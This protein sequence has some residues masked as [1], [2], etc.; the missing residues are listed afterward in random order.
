MLS[1]RDIQRKIRTVRNIQQ[2][3]RA[4][5]TVSS[6][7]LRKAEERIRAARPYADALREMV[8]RLGGVE[9]A[10][11]LL[12]RREVHRVCVVAISADKGLAG[13]Y[14]TNVIRDAGTLVRSLGNALT[15]PVGK[16]VTDSFRRQGFDIDTAVSPLGGNPEFRTFASL[17]DHIGELYTQGLFDRVDLVYTQFGNGVQTLQLLPIEPPS[18]EEIF[19]DFIYEPSPSAI[20]D[21]ILPRYLRT[22]L[23]TAALSA[24][25]AEQAARV[26]AM[27]LATENAEDMIN[28]LTMEFNK[29]RQ[30]TITRELGEIV[31]AAEALR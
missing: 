28:Q 7:K 6:I 20:L 12:Q 2:I 8:A 22:M 24:V 14:N 30:S 13:S 9:Y 16:K 10:H 19:G 4:M 29:S 31:G 23:Y 15:I 25:A 3:T 27:S 11:P 18:D 5:K 17:G 26:A 1:T 21:Q